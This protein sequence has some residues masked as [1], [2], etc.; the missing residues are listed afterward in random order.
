[1]S[2][3]NAGIWAGICAAEGSG[4]IT[5]YPCDTPRPNAPN[6]NYTGGQTI[7]NNVIVKTGTGGTVCWY[8]QQTTHL[9]ADINGAFG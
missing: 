4:Y 8:S 5:A 7:P 3:I 1:M 6:L 9:I 2:A